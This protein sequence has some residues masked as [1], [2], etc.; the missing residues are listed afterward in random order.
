MIALGCDPVGSA[1]RTGVA[2]VEMKEIDDKGDIAYI[3]ATGQTS[4]TAARNHGSGEP[5]FCRDLR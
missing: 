5:D 4:A 3:P 1:W 2:Q